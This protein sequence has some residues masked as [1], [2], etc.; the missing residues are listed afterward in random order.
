MQRH[1]QH[2]ADSGPKQE[3]FPADSDA[4]DSD[5]GEEEY[6]IVIEPDDDDDEVDPDDWDFANDADKWNPDRPVRP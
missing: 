6:F 2:S 4:D 5:L 3:P 1:D